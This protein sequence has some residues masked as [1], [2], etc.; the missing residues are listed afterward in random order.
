M[1]RVQSSASFLVAAFFTCSAA[2]PPAA[3]ADGVDA[4]SSDAAGIHAFW[5]TLDAIWRS[6]DAERFSELFAVDGSF[7]FVDRDYTLENRAAILDYF[8]A[9]FPNIAPGISHRTKVRKIRPLAPRTHA[10]DA[11]VEI[12]RDAPDGQAQPAVLRT[13]AVFGVMQRSGDDW[14]IQLLSAYQLPVAEGGG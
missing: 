6:G 10:V 5:S 8:T 12:L 11:T 7:H 13:F 4:N 3:V 1:R 9:Q 14:H 2:F